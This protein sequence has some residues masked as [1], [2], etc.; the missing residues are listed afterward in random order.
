METS[1]LN[2]SV[3]NIAVILFA[4]TPEEEIR[5][6][7]LSSNPEENKKL[8]STLFKHT[9]GETNRTGLPVF[10]FSEKE[11]QGSSFGEKLVN[12]FEFV[13]SQGYKNAILIGSD[14][15]QLSHFNLQKAAAVLSSGYSDVVLG[16]SMDGGMYLIGLN[17]SSFHKEIILSTSWQ[18]GTDYQQFSN[19]LRK[20]GY[21]IHS[22]ARK[23][24]V[25]QGLILEWLLNNSL[26]DRRL[27][28][29]LS[30]IVS[31]KKP[32]IS[33]II[34]NCLSL[35]MRQNIGLRAPPIL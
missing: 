13:F 8:A 29:L 14:C 26:L 9:L 15:P 12:A 30:A 21:K 19:Q 32:H 5:R 7:A 28:I 23:A 35:L 27:Y 33:L 10:L 6:K 1:A 11:Q 4:Y 3:K 18:I 25:D 20:A 34:N 22:L 31:I 24:D 16:P 2:K 17:K